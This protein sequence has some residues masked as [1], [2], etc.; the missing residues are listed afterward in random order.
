MRAGIIAGSIA[1]LVAVLVSLP[2]HAPSDTLFNSISVTAA[3]L[4]A[5]LAAAAIWNA[6][7]SR[8]GGTRAYAVI[9]V[10][11]IVAILGMSVAGETQFK[12]MAEFVAPLAVTVG[13]IAGVGVP[14]IDRRTTDARW[15]PAAVLV[16]SLV[17]GA[18]LVGQGDEQS[19]RLSLPAPASTVGL[20]VTAA[21]TSPTATATLAV[22]AAGTA[23]RTASATAAPAAAPVNIENRDDLA[24]VTFVVGEGSEA[25]FTVNE[26]LQRLPLPNDAVMR[27]EALVGSV[28][29]DGWPTVIEIDLHELT[30]DQSRRDGYVRNR[31]FQSEPVARF[32]VDALPV[33]PDDYAPGEVFEADVTGLLT[34]D[35]VERSV[36]FEIEARLNGDVLFVV[37]RLQFT[38]DDFEIRPPNVSIVQVQDD[39]AA[40][41]LIVA[42]ATRD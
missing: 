42:R 24:G 39:V 6:T 12:R 11:V 2:L 14:L 27:T 10:S 19:G 15:P 41:V 38:W 35:G 7:K 31:M 37:G 9:W 40:E 17:V 16:A 23:Q 8:D 36:T 30:S 3:A 32:V 1:A 22:P 33:L 18:A 20:T 26:K 13:L 25:T 5:G 29:L 34:I 21:S 4:I 28:Y